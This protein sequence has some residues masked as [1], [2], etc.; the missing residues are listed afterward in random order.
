[1]TLFQIISI[2]IC[3]AALFSYINFRY[4]KLPTVIGLML[5]AMLAS[6]TLLLLGP[7]TQG[8]EEQVHT[9]ISTIDFNATLLHGMLSLLLFA[10]ALHVNLED[11]A[12]QR[13]VISILAT[14]GVLSAT[15]FVGYMAYWTFSFLGLDIPLIYCLLFGALIAPT[16][17]IA[18][19]GILAKA[20]ASK[21]LET[22]II[23][24]S[25]FNDGVSV[26]V[27]LV[28]LGIATGEGDTSTLS[29]AGLFA[30]EVIGG[31]L[32]GLALGGL[33]YW[34]LKQVDDYT[35]EVLITLA[36]TTGGYALAE[37]LHLSA[38]IA[39]VVMGLLI[40]N[41]GRVFAMSDKSREHLDNFWKLVDEILNAVL[42]V[43][44]GMEV[45]VLAFQQEYLLA[46]LLMIPIALFARL[47][48]VGSCIGVMRNYRKFSPMAVSIM[49]WGGL[50][51]GISVALALSL[52]AGE[53]R[54]ALVTIT[55]IVVAFSIIIQGLT[56]GP[57]V[58]FAAQRHSKKGDS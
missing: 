19:L 23:G 7:L 9:L 40:G 3:L 32:Y 11:L 28:L 57:L 5:I 10:G 49:T 58:K 24:E 18:V 1:M 37:A 2:L 44:I 47:V 6:L 33:A 50:R 30:Q 51:G 31:T 15:F 48:A 46:G 53:V 16:D 45:M 20:G 35:V 21:T 17:P 39:I 36:L 56:V 42:F 43:L 12:K 29:I 55:Y 52:P 54:D 14:A 4:L 13:W 34:M 27:F 41:H 8:V 26:V 38:P 25:L 22:K